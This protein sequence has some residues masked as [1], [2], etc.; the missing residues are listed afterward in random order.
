MPGTTRLLS[1]SGT[2]VALLTAPGIAAQ[3]SGAELLGL[4]GSD[5]TAH[6]YFAWNGT[7]WGRLADAVPSGAPV[8]MV[9]SL[10]RTALGS[11]AEPYDPWWPPLMVYALAGAE[12]IIDGAASFGFQYVGY[13]ASP[14]VE[15]AP[16]VPTELTGPTPDWAAVVSSVLPSPSTGGPDHLTVRVWRAASGDDALTYFVVRRQAAERRGCPAMHL[17]TGWLRLTNSEPVVAT[18]AQGDCDGKGATFRRPVALI[19]HNER[20]S[21]LVAISDWEAHGI[22]LWDLVDDRLELADSLWGN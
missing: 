2:V 18:S 7:A 5:A 22:E 19:V 9:D 15:H 14:Q 17:F 1:I 20:L 8:V 3:N 6:V 16:F 4:L 12:T 13:V 21:V 10:G 11:L